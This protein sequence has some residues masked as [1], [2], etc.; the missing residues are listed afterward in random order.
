[1]AERPNPAD[2]LVKAKGHGEDNRNLSFASDAQRLSQEEIEA[3]KSEG[4]A[5]GDIITALMENR[6]DVRITHMCQLPLTT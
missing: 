3:M 2:L 6:F 1:M 4:L 5:A